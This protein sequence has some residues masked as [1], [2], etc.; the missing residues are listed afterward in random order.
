MMYLDGFNLLKHNQTDREK[1]IWKK[2]Y[3]AKLTDIPS[4]A[5]GTPRKTKL[6][7]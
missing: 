6:V 7:L 5:P 4:K 2:S 3:E 1:E